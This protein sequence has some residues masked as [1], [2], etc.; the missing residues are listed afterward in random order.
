MW[1]K[2]VHKHSLM[3]RVLSLSGKSMVPQHDLNSVKWGVKLKT[4]QLTGPGINV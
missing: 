1:W 3:L 4:N 2:N